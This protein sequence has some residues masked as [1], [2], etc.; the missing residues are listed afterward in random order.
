[1][2]LYE[3]VRLLAF[4]VASEAG[5]QEAATPPSEQPPSTEQQETHSSSMNYLQ[6]EP[7]STGG[8]FRRLILEQL[9]AE[10]PAHSVPDTVVLVPALCLTPHGE[11][12]KHIL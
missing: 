9:R 8:G 4:I 11:R 1:M 3:G 5:E 7:D 6:E 12:H 10:L 2:T